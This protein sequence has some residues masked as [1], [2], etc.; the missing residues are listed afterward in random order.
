MNDEVQK[1]KGLHLNKAYRFLEENGL[2]TESVEIK[3]SSDAFMSYTSTLRRAKIIDLVKRKNML[4]QFLKE[5]WPSGVTEKGL[6]KIKFFE[7][8]YQRYLESKGNITVD[9]YFKKEH[10]DLLDKYAGTKYDPSNSDQKEAR[11]ELKKAYDVTK[12]WAERVTKILFPNG[13]EKSRRNPINQG[14]V[15]EE[16]NWAKI[17]PDN[18]QNKI[19]FTVGIHGP[20][21]NQF[22]VKVDT[23]GL[24]EKDEL[25]EK[26][27][28]LRGDFDNSN[29]VYILTKEEGLSMNLDELVEWSIDKVEK[30]KPY[31]DELTQQR[32][33]SMNPSSVSSSLNQILYGPPGTGKTYNT[34]NQALSILDPGYLDSH[35]ER[36][37]LKQ[38]FDELKQEGRIGFVTFHQSFSYEDFVEGLR[39]V[40]NDG[41]I[42]YSVEPV[43]FKRLCKRASKNDGNDIDGAIENLK[44]R[45]SEEPVLMKTSRGKEFYVTYRGTTTFIIEPLGSERDIEHRANIEYVKQYYY[46][47]LQKPFYNSS[48]VQ[49]I[50]DYLLRENN[51]NVENPKQMNSEPVVLIID[52]INRGNTANIFGELITLIEPSKRYGEI[53]SLQVT[54]PYSKELFHVPNSLYIIGTMNTA[55]RSLSLLDTALRRRFEF[56]FMPPMSS[57]L[58]EN[59]IIEVDGIKISVMLETINKRIELLYDRDHAIGHSFFLELKVD[60]TINKLAD[61]FSRN[62]LPLLEEYFFEDWF[63]IQQVLGDHL[64]SNNAH[65]FIIPAFDNNDSVSQLLGSEYAEMLGEKVYKR[66][67]DALYNKDAYIGIYTRD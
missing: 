3:K 11:D 58:T 61:I 22:I 49:G 23:V 8:L 13:I 46:G 59:G 24:G 7:T 32:S 12:K 18:K 17:Y 31:Y 27:L 63:K 33:V 26:Y 51:L 50:L 53:E 64:K 57:V 44:D 4:D 43:I 35:S 37:E 1:Y 41:N 56:E 67:E 16:Y 14:Q 40:E 19:A 34:I 10:F 9:D 39:A 60:N 25:R 36:I 2:K 48:Y 38:R 65:K 45:S 28:N 21:K 6:S 52:E 5:V 30:L 29:L 20:K 66:N 42:S 47:Q 54:L 15:F 62:I 55:D